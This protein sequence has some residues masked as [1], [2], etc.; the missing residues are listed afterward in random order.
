MEFIENAILEYLKD[1]SFT[2]EEEFQRLKVVVARQSYAL[3]MTLQNDHISTTTK[4]LLPVFTP[5]HPLL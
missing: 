1:F 3:P 2:G 5:E 4:V